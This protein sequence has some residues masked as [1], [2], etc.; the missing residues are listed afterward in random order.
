MSGIVLPDPA[1]VA[2]A[3]ATLK[4]QGIEARSFWK[5]MHLQEPYRNAPT[6]ELDICEGLWPRVLL[7]PC[8]SNL[9][10]K[11]Q[12]KVISAILELTA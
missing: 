4:Q 8:S 2:A 3:V 11:D 9:S 7:L 10:E 6:A 12:E 1:T 5:P